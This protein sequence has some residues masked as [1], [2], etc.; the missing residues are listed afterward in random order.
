MDK[1]LLKIPHF[2]SKRTSKK[3]F[4]KDVEPDIH[5]RMLS[6]RFVTQ[7][8]RTLI[9]G[10]IADCPHLSEVEMDVDP[11]HE[12]FWFVGG[13]VPPVRVKGMRQNWRSS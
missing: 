11:R 8:N 9:N 6:S 12:A 4:S 7:I 13:I 3:Q 2:P 10:L 1:L 5:R